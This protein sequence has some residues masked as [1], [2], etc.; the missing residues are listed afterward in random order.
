MMQIGQRGTLF[1]FQGDEIHVGMAN[2]PRSWPIEEYKDVAT[3][4]IYDR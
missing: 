2:A 3:Q 4:R 1:I